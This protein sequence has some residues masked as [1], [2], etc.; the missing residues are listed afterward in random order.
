MAF[1]SEEINFVLIP[2]MAP[3]HTIPMVDLAKLLASRGVTITILLTSLHATRFKAVIDRAV[4][5]GLLIRLRQLQFPA[6]EAGLPAGC[7]SFDALP[8][9]FLVT[10]FFAA[11]NKLRDPAE[12][13]IEEITPR[14]RCIICDRNIHW[15]A[16]TAEKFQI[17]RILFDGMSCFSQMS[18]HNLYILQ[19]DNRIPETAPFL[20]PD[21][22]D[23]IEVRRAQ[24]PGAFNPGTLDMGDVRE[25]IRASEA[26]AYG[27]IINSFEEL[28]QKYVE[29][30]RKVKGG[31]NVWCV[32]PLSLCNEDSVDKAQR[33][34]PT[35][36]ID[37]ENFL[38]WL[39][40]RQPGSVVYA[41]LGSLARFTI[42][43]FIELALGLE[44]SNRPFIL[45]VKA[46]DKQLEVERWI[47]ENQF[48]E[49]VQ[50][51]SLLIRGW[52]PQVLILSHPSIGAFLTHCGWNST[53][54]GIT[55]GVPLI[56]WPLFAEQFLNE[57]FVLNVIGTGVSVGSES[58]MFMLEEDR[59]KRKVGRENVRS[60]IERA[61]EQGKE[62]NRVR[63][64]ARKV[65][66]MAKKAVQVGGSSHLNLT[67]LIQQIIISAQNN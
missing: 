56:T 22:P 62:G 38:K 9:Y 12:K 13:I 58:I 4:S 27:Y 47:S 51:R 34:N 3:G 1:C 50:N 39:D 52:A 31:K 40:S 11:I 7:E 67:L 29:E 20:I 23:R 45:V 41:C 65:G 36:S 24:L 37:Q 5:S 10:N 49:R 60:A 6:E 26:G 43:Q 30:F 14:P 16:Q 53:L 33:G 25:Q 15:T 28:E 48:E 21:M 63:E 19:D 55:A 66:E 2:L 42:A 17:P 18:I 44:D 61:M 46:G 64:A 32:G 35:T 8:S 59:S 57:K 54:E